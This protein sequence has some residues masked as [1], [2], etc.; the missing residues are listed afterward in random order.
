MKPQGREDTVSAPTA[1]ACTFAGHFLSWR[2][3]KAEKNSRSH[4][5]YEK[6][7]PSI[8]VVAE[9]GP[10]SGGA[11]EGEVMTRGVG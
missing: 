3:R 7:S 5:V 10:T 8:S 11:G 9:L 6:N 2:I 1:T 4:C